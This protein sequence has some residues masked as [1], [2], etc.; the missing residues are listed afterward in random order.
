MP[1]TG[2][3]G[4]YDNDELQYLDR[5]SNILQDT[6]NDYVRRVIA[7]VLQFLRSVPWWMMFPMLMI[8][9]LLLIIALFVGLKMLLVFILSDLRFKRRVVAAGL[10]FV[11]V[12]IF[13]M[14]Y[15]A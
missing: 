10:V 11:A 13:V 4:S 1:G 14:F 6:P 9:V 8:F 5:H 12:V 15:Q 2:A 3:Y 7:L